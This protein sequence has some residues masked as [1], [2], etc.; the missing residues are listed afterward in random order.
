MLDASGNML[1]ELRE[2]ALRHAEALEEL[3]LS[4]NWL[5]LIH[6]RAFTH[7]P[8]LASLDLSHNMLEALRPQ[9]LQP[10]ERTLKR[11]ALH[12]EWPSL[13]SPSAPQLPLLLGHVSR[14]PSHHPPYEVSHPAHSP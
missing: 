12:G 4:D 5:T 8:R 1:T 6:P 13:P 2:G 11:L 7:L 14:L 3:I 10:V 9:V